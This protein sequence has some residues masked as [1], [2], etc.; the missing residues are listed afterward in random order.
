MANASVP[1]RTHPVLAQQ[2][3]G[4]LVACASTA[5]IS[6]FTPPIIMCSNPAE[7]L[8]IKTFIGRLRMHRR[9]G[10][11]VASDSVSVRTACIPLRRAALKLVAPTRT[12]DPNEQA[13]A[14]L[15][16]ALPAIDFARPTI[17]MQRARSLPTTVSRPPAL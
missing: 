13:V 17:M 3:G 6:V 9:S 10:F 1:V 16:N 2:R 11:L 12:S 4:F 15:V 7:N 8:K 5:I 14:I